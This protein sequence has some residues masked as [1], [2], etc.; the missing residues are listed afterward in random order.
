MSLTEGN[1][2]IEKSRES[3]QT[4][5]DQIQTLARTNQRLGEAAVAAETV[6]AQATFA[7]AFIYGTLEITATYQGKRIR[8]YGTM[9]GVGLGGGTTWGALTLTLP[10]SQLNNLECSFQ[11]TTAPALVEIQTWNDQ[12]GYVANF[13]GA[14]LAIGAGVTG[15]TGKWTVS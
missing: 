10:V 15:G 2:Y 14:G 6:E 3:A 4:M 12:Y 8:F 9:W 5:I 13:T 7:T 1:P 11:L